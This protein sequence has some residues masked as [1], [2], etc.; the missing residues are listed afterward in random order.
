MDRMLEQIRT[1]DFP[2]QLPGTLL[3][4]EQTFDRPC[5]GDVAS[6]TKTALDRLL[7]LMVP[8]RRVAVG[9]GSRGIANLSLIVKTTIAALKNA[10][11]QPFIFPAMGSHAG[12][13][14]H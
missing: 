13:F 9:V 11:L 3:A 14:F 12:L 7:P 2:A 8:G 1:L 4:V 6:A 10:G 5:A